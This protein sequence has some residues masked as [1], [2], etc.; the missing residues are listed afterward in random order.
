MAEVRVGCSGFMYDHWKGAFYPGDLP[1]REWF[2]HYAAVFDTVELNVTFYRLP[3]PESFRRWYERSPEGFSFSIKGSRY[4]THVRRLE[5]T[6]EALGRFFE[7]AL[8][9]GEKLSV[10]LWQ[11]PPGF[12][13]EPSRLEE[14]L[15]LLRDYRMVR[16]AFEFRHQGWIVPEVT[17]LLR[18]EGH[19]FCMADW[20]AFANELP[21]TADFVYIRRHGHGGRYDSCYSSGE[22]RSDAARIRAY[23]EKGLDVYV[24]FN[25]DAFGYAPRNATELKEML[26]RKR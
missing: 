15:R 23:L 26:R 24:Y 3:K 12:G 20:P 1:K 2:G 13:P 17:S 8:N 4:I 18:E 19:A 5:G 22:L 11:F 14:F 25:N 9:L 21:V 6:A 7:P 10:V 16:H